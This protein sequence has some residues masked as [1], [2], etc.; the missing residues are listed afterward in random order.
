MTSIKYRVQLLTLRLTMQKHFASP[1]SLHRQIAVA[2]RN[3]DFDPP[4]HVRENF[5][6]VEHEWHGHP[7][8]EMAPLGRRP[9]LHIL[10]LHGGANVFELGPMHW[11]FLAALARRKDAR[12][13]VPVYPLAPEHNWHDVHA[14]LKPLYAKVARQAGD[15]TLVLMGD[16]SGG[17]LAA[18]LALELAED[19]QRPADQLLLLSP[20]LDASLSN[21]SI[22]EF[23]ADDPWLGIEAMREAARLYAGSD[24]LKD[25]RISPI[26]GNL[27]ALPPTQI[28]IGTHDILYPDCV[29]FAEIAYAC[30]ATIDLIYE[31]EMFHVWMMFDMPEARRTLDEMAAGLPTRPAVAF[32]G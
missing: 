13:I 30:G 6:M 1:E 8:F 15:G 23:A 24:D 20:W 29:S 5:S 2:R 22:A 11:N 16:S 9:N 12:I 26:Y 4:R 14:I 27:E 19:G 32:A 17:G 25:H 3:R 21:H 18:S 10:Y 7:V 31:P 28:Y